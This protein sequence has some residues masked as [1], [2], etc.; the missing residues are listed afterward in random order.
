[1]PNWKKLVTSGSDASLRTLFVGTSVTASIV[2]ASSGITGSLFGSAT[3]ASFALTASFNS[4]ILAGTVLSES[5]GRTVTGGPFTASVVFQQALSNTNYSISVQGVSLS[6]STPP[7]VI[8][9]TTFAKSTTGFKI[10]HNNITPSN[11]VNYD[12]IVIRY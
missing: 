1:M 3:S 10:F 8:T 12:W 5:F 9:S 11:L 2:S 4:N 6:T 7:G